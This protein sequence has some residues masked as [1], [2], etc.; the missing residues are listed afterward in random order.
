MPAGQFELDRQQSL[1]LPW[2]PASPRQRVVLI[3]ALGRDSIC[4]Q[5]HLFATLPP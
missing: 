3:D 2:V 1:E 5:G 4:Q